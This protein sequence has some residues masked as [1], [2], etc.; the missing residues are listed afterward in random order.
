[1]TSPQEQKIK[2]KGPVVVTA[3]RLAD[4]AV[5]YR[6]A[7]Q[8]WSRHL[9]D[10]LVATTTPAASELLA[11][12]VADDIGAVGAYIAPVA[13]AGADIQPGNLRE[14]IRLKGLTFDLP[15]TFGI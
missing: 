6:T 1:M 13:L 5:V 7:S 4:G 12:A 3:N 8:T 11:S 10:A 15:V 14:R 9:K 2:I